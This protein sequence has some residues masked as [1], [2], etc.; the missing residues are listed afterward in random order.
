MK[1]LKTYENTILNNILDKIYKSGISSLTKHEKEFLNK[2]SNNEPTKDVQKEMNA[3]TFEGEIGPYDA[4]LILYNIVHNDNSSVW[5]SKLI[6][7]DIEYTGRILFQD[8]NYLSGY[9]YNE[10][11]DAFTDFE[12]LE[13]EIDSFLIESFNEAIKNI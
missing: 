4:K 9:F 12:G 13:Y 5:I 7:N 6:I 3:T 2:F 10:K 11:S 1:F 8:E